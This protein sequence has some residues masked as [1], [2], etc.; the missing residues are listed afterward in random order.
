MVV[1][2]LAFSVMSLFVKLTGDK[3]VPVLEIVAARSVVSLV[4][5]AVS[6][7]RLGIAFFGQR[8]LL[9]LSRG[10]VGFIALNCLFY[11][12]THLPLAEATVIQ[13]LHPMFTAV[14][15]FIFLKERFSMAT[16]ACLTI[17]FIG[18]LFVVRPEL[19]FSTLP[20]PLDEVAVLAALAGA[21][22][23]AVAYVLVRS[24][25]KTEHP[26]VIV[27]YFPLVSLPF[28]VLML[29]NDFVMPQGLTWFY[30]LAVGVSTQIGQVALTRAMQTET[31]SRAT[32]FAYLQ[33][34]FAIILGLVFY[35]EVPNS[36]TVIGAG[37]IVMAA[38]L[39]VLWHRKPLA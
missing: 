5:S 24:L 26:L 36:G 29:W 31:A 39:N 4:I 1:S 25:G 34:V 28:S 33:V 21:L 37:F 16:L 27:L 10:L 14:L 17:S 9:L 2:A 7:Q 13:Y 11:A 22:G 20:Q 38:Y 19:A 6:I 32:S 3:G 18:L 8:K 23:S 12:L 30:L 35:Q 15:A